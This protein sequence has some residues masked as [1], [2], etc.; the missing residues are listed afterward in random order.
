MALVK[1]VTLDKYEIVGKWKIIQIRELVKITENDNVVSTSYHRRSI[2]PGQDVSQESQEIR[3]IVAA[4]HTQSII[5]AYN[6]AFTLQ[7]SE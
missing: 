1:N 7:G 3:T 4:L 5:N 2:V 6:E